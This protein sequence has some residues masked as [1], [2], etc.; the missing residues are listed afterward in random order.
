MAHNQEQAR[1]EYAAMIECMRAM[2]EQFNDFLD[3]CYSEVGPDDVTWGH[4]GFLNA[5]SSQLG[6]ALDMAIN[7]EV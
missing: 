5:V 3:D 1:D 4:V 2:L 6:L 7:W